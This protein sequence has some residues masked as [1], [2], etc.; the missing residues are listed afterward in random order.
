MGNWSYFTLLIGVVTPSRTARGPP[1]LHDSHFVCFKLQSSF[2]R[3]IL[4][5][6]VLKKTC[7]FLE[8]MQQEGSHILFVQNDLENCGL[9]QYNDLL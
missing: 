2:N 3:S 5:A 6:H 4:D 9:V 8:M 1:T 7:F